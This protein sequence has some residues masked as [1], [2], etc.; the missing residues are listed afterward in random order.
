MTMKNPREI[1]ITTGNLEYDNMVCTFYY[2][3]FFAIDNYEEALN[4]QKFWEGVIFQEE[5]IDD[6]LHKI[7]AISKCDPDVIGGNLLFLS[8][9]GDAEIKLSDF[10]DKEELEQMCF[11]KSLMFYFGMMES[12]KKSYSQN[13]QQIKQF[14]KDVVLP[15][16][17]LSVFKTIIDEHTEELF[18]GLCADYSNKIKSIDNEEFIRDEIKEFSR[19]ISS[20]DDSDDWEY[21]K[22]RNQFSWFHEP[23]EIRSVAVDLRN[24]FYYRLVLLNGEEKTIISEVYAI[25]RY[26]DFLNTML[27]E[28]NK[29]Y[30]IQ[31]GRKVFKRPAF[32]LTEEGKTK[33]QLA[34]LVKDL[35]DGKIIEKRNLAD[36][37]EIFSGTTKVKINFVRKGHGGGGL[38]DVLWFMFF[39]SEE[40][41]I[42]EK[43]NKDNFR[44]LI[45]SCFLLKN[46]PILLDEKGLEMISTVFSQIKGEWILSKGEILKKKFERARPSKPYD[47]IKIIYNSVKNAITE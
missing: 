3:M 13:P 31:T 8:E 17:D 41:K 39:M 46:Q 25:D 4:Q 43:E 22:K 9:F 29:E 44:Q 42:V 18:K 33:L 5:K 27:I 11:A 23:K 30:N 1:K 20:S 12:L 45:P 24:G 47:R 14:A 28:P 6:V 35:C 10:A 7:Y 16:E 40:F 21:F 15:L 37:K 26:I 34:K 19:L 2:R 36:F 32:F 38:I